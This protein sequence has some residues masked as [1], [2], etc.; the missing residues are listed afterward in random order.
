MS[1]PVNRR[2]R[3]SGAGAACYF[4][5][6]GG[7]QRRGPLRSEAVPELSVVSDDAPAAPRAWPPLPRQAP[8]CPARRVLPPPSASM[9]PDDHAAAGVRGCAFCLPRALAPV[10]TMSMAACC[11]RARAHPAVAGAVA[12]AAAAAAVA[13]VAAAVGAMLAMLKMGASAVAMPADGVLSATATTLHHCLPELV[14]RRPRRPSAV[15]A[16]PMQ[17][18]CNIVTVHSVAAAR[19]GGAVPTAR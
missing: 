4:H 14:S 3:C 5:R 10:V 7:P 1:F 12:A 17:L 16:G 9:H 2:C 18:Y 19:I 11:P 6:I 13:A 8:R 15:A